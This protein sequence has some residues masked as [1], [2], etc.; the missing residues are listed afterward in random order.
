MSM[1]AEQPRTLRQ[2]IARI[3][4]WLRGYHTETPTIGKF[5]LNASGVCA[6]CGIVGT[7]DP[8]HGDPQ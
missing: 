4:C 7:G 5:G 6:D 8:D 2:R 3:R 1:T